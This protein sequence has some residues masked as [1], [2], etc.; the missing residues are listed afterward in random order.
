MEFQVNGGSIS[1]VE[2]DADYCIND[3]VRVNVISDRPMYSYAFVLESIK[4]GG[5]E[6]P[7]KHLI[8]PSALRPRK[9]MPAST[10]AAARLR[11]T[12][13]QVKRRRNLFT[14]EEDL[15]LLRT[16]SQPGIALNGN[17]VYE[18]LADRYPARTMHSWRGRWVDHFSKSNPDPE[19]WYKR[20]S[21]GRKGKGVAQEDDVE[22]GYEGEAEEPVM[23]TKVTVAR[24]KFAPR[25][26][27]GRNK[28]KSLPT[29]GDDFT[30]QD[31]DILMAYHSAVVKAEDPLEAWEKLSERARCSGHEG[32]GKC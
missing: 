7:E 5:L 3:P 21:T 6:D 17:K 12:G 30:L 19:W 1:R 28:S 29:L 31:D 15:I 24:P 11:R 20:L 23:P 13:N 25:S 26:T 4:R 10:P 14:P 16:I 27:L 18:E 9:S 22:D 32:V 8:D 2:R